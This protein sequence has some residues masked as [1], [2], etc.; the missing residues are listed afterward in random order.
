MKTL[1]VLL[2]A[3]ALAG[4]A[5]IKVM[6]LDGQSGGPYHDWR[7]TTPVMKKQLEQ[8]GLF[9]VDV[10]TAP[11][12]GSDF[13]NFRPD[14]SKYQV[15]VSNLDSPEWP[16]EL[17][18]S[19]ERYMKNGGGLVVV[20]AADNAFP[21]WKEYNLMIGIGGWRG[22]NAESGPMWYVKDGK[23]VSDPAPGNAGSHGARLPFQITARDPQHP[24]LKGLPPVWMHAPDELY[25]TLRGPGENM[26]ILATGHSDPANKG[27]GHDEPMLMAI[28]YGKGRVF[29]TTLG[30]DVAALKCAGFATTFQRGT[31]WAATGKVTQKVPAD[32]PSADKISIRA[33]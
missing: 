16:S 11:P 15:V 21:K 14:F 19:F 22:R 30:H 33:D 23:V 18:T 32:F 10:V 1:F 8:T 25:A 2:C 28:Q 20:H 24:V 27:T 4:A 5:P 3:A 13:S 17:M 31:E 6:L 29:H 12:S 7:A 26:K 9:Q